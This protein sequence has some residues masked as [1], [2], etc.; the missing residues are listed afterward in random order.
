MALGTFATR[1]AEQVDVVHIIELT[2]RR[3]MF[4]RVLRCSKALHTG[5]IA[6]LRSVPARSRL[7][8]ILLSI[9]ITGTLAGGAVAGHL[10]WWLV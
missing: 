9:W 5:I 7:F 1:I 10:L 2:F 3:S 6:V 4:Q 8:I